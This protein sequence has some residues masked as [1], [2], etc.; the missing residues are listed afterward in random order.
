M[1]PRLFRCILLF[2]FLLLLNGRAQSTNE[3]SIFP[4]KNL[5]AAVRQQ[6]FAKRYTNSPLTAADVANVST[7]IGNFRGITD[8]TGLE[9]CK[10]LAALELAGNKIKDLKPIS[11]LRQLQQVILTSNKV[12]EITPLGTLPALQYIE[13]SHNGVKDI[14]PLAKAT[15]LAS[16]YVGHNKVASIAPLTSLPRLVTLYAESNEIRS[17]DGLQNVRSLSGISLSGNRISDVSALAGLRSPTFI[18]LE[19]N[20]VKDLSGWSEWV[21]KDLSGPRSFAPYLQL[22]L[23]GNPLNAKSK[24]LLTDWSKQGMRVAQ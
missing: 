4:D 10:S 22:Y 6:V 3:A 2:P 9:H 5:E 8:L 21:S 24:T 14:T 15:N 20:R 7:V 16:V 23:K 1:V 17:V 19:K 11:G 12:S 18:F 13:L